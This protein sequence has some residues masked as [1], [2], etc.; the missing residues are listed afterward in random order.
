MQD[1]IIFVAVAYDEGLISEVVR[2]R[3]LDLIK[4]VWGRR[5]E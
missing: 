2:D 3:C 5:L 1:W 4:L